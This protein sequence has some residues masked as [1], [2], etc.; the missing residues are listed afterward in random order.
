MVCE[1]AT[2]AARSSCTT[3]LLVPD[4]HDRKQLPHKENNEPTTNAA[5]GRFPRPTERKKTHAHINAGTERHARRATRQPPPVPPDSAVTAEQTSSRVCTAEE[6]LRFG[7]KVLV[8]TGVPEDDAHLLADSLV[9]AELWGHSSHGML[10]LP[11]YVARLRTGAIKPV[12][13]STVV[14]DTGSVV[15]I[16]GNDGLGQVLTDNAVTLGV[17]RARRHGISGIAV[18][19]SNHFGT[20]AYFTRR[21]AEQGCVA[22]LFTN[23]SPAMAPWGGKH[24]SVGTNPW[25]IAAPA[26]SRGVAV[27][28]L[29]NTAVARGKIYLAAERDEEIPQG[30]VADANGTPTTN[31]KAGIGGVLLP[32]AGPKGYV[33]SF[34]IDVLAGILTGSAFGD[35]V[36]GP[37]DPTRRSGCGHLLLTIDV[38]ALADPNDFAQRMQQLIDDTKNVERASGV[39]EIFFPGEME[40]RTKSLRLTTGIPVAAETWTSIERLAHETGVALPA[41]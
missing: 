30:W 19:N 1:S 17:E 38:A 4:V 35:K 23:A 14:S 16:D 5:R 40:D 10:R 15:V 29:A 36:V 34:M 32:M 12:V 27:M 8:E 37:Y 33:I 24:K 20:A 9:T 31:A 13:E 2:I 6:L 22:V 21:A 26:G 3:P 25:S 18:R 11:W 28:D 7:T 41:T 39:E